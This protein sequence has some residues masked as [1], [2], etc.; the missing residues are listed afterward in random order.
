MLSTSKNKWRIG[1]QITAYNYIF[2]VVSVLI[3]YLGSAITGKHAFSMVI[4]PRTTLVN[5]NYQ[6]SDMSLS[7]GKLFRTANSMIYKPLIFCVLLYCTETCTLLR[8]DAAALMI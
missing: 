1:S 8:S 3:F 7:S 2:V 6:G 5:M 4:K